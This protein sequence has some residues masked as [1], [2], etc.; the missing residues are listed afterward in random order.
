MS[1]K[2]YRSQKKVSSK[3]EGRLPF[4]P[5][6]SRLSLAFPR[7]L[8]F[9]SWSRSSFLA[10]PRSHPCALMWRLTVWLGRFAPH[11]VSGL[12]STSAP[13]IAPALPF[14]VSTHPVST[15]TSGPG[16]LS[17]LLLNDPP[18]AFSPLLLSGA[19]TVVGTCAS[20]TFT[21]LK[22]ISMLPQHSA[23]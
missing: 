23:S 8:T 21:L 15:Q 6:M 3:P 7:T 11:R 4:A 9:P 13:G 1:E 5:A 14:P 10:S 20:Y 18:L 17:S 19:E 12:W 16:F 2:D 22:S